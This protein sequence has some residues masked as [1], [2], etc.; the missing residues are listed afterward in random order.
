MANG[1]VRNGNNRINPCS[2]LLYN[3]R[4]NKSSVNTGDINIISS[5]NENLI[6]APK[7]LY[8]DK[9]HTWAFMEKDGIV[10]VG[11]DDFIQ[12]ITGTITRI[13]MKEPGER[14]RKGEKILTIIQG[15][16]TTKYKCT[17]F[18]NYK[19]KEPC[20]DCRLFDY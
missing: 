2:M 5:L 8:F 7:G 18:R 13:K 15:W 16:Q 3:L 12:H 19:R 10:K 14:V 20:S 4:S 1:A 9:S 11:I 17:G 6:A